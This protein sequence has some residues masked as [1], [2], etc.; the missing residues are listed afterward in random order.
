MRLKH[1]EKH[2]EGE[3]RYNAK[4]VRKVASLAARLQSQQQEGVT[5]QEMEAIAAEVGLETLSSGRRWRSSP[6][7]RAHTRPLALGSNA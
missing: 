7:G 1:H 5:A 2:V 3:P 4:T 6:R